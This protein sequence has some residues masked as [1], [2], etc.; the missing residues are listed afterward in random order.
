MANKVKLDLT[1]GGLEKCIDILGGLK[2][3]YAEKVAES[4]GEGKTPAKQR[5]PSKRSSNGNKTHL[6]NPSV[7]ELL[8]PFLKHIMIPL[9]GNVESFEKDTEIWATNPQWQ[10]ILDSYHPENQGLSLKQR[11]GTSN[12]LNA[13]E[14][15]VL[16]K[17][18]TGTKRQKK[19]VGDQVALAFSTGPDSPQL[20]L[21]TFNFGSAYQWMKKQHPLPLLSHET[22]VFPIFQRKRGNLEYVSTLKTFTQ[23]PLSLMIPLG[24]DGIRGYT[25]S[26]LVSYIGNVFLKNAEYS[27]EVFYFQILRTALRLALGNGPSNGGDDWTSPCYSIEDYCDFM[28]D[29]SATLCCKLYDQKGA[30]LS[31][32][33]F[34]FWNADCIQK[35]NE[36]R[37]DRLLSAFATAAQTCSER[38]AKLQVRNQQ[39]LTRVARVML[40]EKAIG[41]MDEFLPRLLESLCTFLVRINGNFIAPKRKQQPVSSADETAPEDV[42]PPPKRRAKK[43]PALAVPDLMAEAVPAPCGNDN[44]NDSGNDDDDDNC[45]QM[46]DS[47]VSSNFN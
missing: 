31:L 39:I 20:G 22:L 1:K 7:G 35:W 40:K 45:S 16:F 25:K 27:G 38:E 29:F 36:V 13:E 21:N 2:D 30:D 5:H 24:V 15:V 9:I 46:S 17:R 18:R 3:L 43:Q 12:R 4:L 34:D 14:S 41:K 42:Q 8:V 26:N 44:D 37:K 23:L 32:A 6:V 11:T 47:S 33:K 28:W 10:S 19:L